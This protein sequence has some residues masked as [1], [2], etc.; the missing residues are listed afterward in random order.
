MSKAGFHEHDFQETPDVHLF[1]R[2]LFLGC[3]F[4]LRFVIVS[5]CEIIQFGRKRCT[6]SIP[7]VM[8]D[9]LK[10]FLRNLL[11]KFLDEF[12]EE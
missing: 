5:V 7:L 4:Y 3:I 12:L 9:Q 8:I 10:K 2:L 6:N 11:E 1:L